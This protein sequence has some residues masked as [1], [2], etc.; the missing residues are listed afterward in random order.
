MSSVH[1][2]L[3]AVAAVRRIEAAVRIAVAVRTVV[4]LLVVRRILVEGLRSLAERL[5]EHRSFAEERRMQA[6][7]LAEVH[8]LDDMI[9]LRLLSRM[10]GRWSRGGARS[11]Y[12]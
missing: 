7:R 10:L 4:G 1:T 12:Q 3:A 11:Y 6:G 5:V 9:G 8:R 2:R